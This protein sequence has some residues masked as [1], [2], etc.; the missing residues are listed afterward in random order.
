MVGAGRRRRVGDDEQGRAGLVPTGEVVEVFVL[1][2]G[3]EI[4]DGLFAGEDDGGAAFELL[5]EG[6]AP[7]V[8]GGR[9]LLFERKRERREKEQSGES[10]DAISKHGAHGISLCEWGGTVKCPL[11]EMGQGGGECFG[12]LD[13]LSGRQSI[14]EGKGQGALGDRLGHRQRRI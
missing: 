1:A 11:G 5:R 7:R 3:C 9:G 10:K 14:E 8:V 12:N 13:G 4:E 2:V 6:G